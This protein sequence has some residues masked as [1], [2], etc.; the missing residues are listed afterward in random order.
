MKIIGIL[1][2][3]IGVG[4]VL[5]MQEPRAHDS[6]CFCIVCLERSEQRLSQLTQQVCHIKQVLEYKKNYAK[7]HGL[8]VEQRAHFEVLREYIKKLKEIFH[9]IKIEKPKIKESHPLSPRDIVAARKTPP[10]PAAENDDETIV[11]T[12]TKL[13]QLYYNPP[14]F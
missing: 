12:N 9:D 4:S 2:I 5:A 13:R 11:L 1:G 10:L 7:E 14:S 6:F 3:V 8:S